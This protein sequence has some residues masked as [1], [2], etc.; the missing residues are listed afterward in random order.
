ML[1]RANDILF[2]E[3]DPGDR[4]YIVRSG[5]VRILKREGGQMNTLAEFGP[6]GF[7]GEMSLLD[8]S[9]RSATVQACE[10][11]ELAVVDQPSLTKT[12]QSQP[13]WLSALLRV[14]TVR[15]RET[16][17]RKSH[18]DLVR[19]FPALLWCIL[20]EENTSPTGIALTNLAARMRSI[21]GLQPES[22]QKLVRAFCQLSLGNLRREDQ[23]EL[24]EIR[25][26]RLLGRLLSARFAR[27][28]GKPDP[29]WILSAGE[30]RI[31]TCWVEAA[32]THGIQEGNVAKVSYTDFMAILKQ[33][34]PGV[35]LGVAALSRME[36]HGI[37]RIEPPQNNL[38]ANFDEILEILECQQMLTRIATEL[39][40][41]IEN[42]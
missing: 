33:R 40:A 2:V 6:G 30:Q 28:H 1:L 14:L 4:M 39:P 17:A 22:C 26:N 32:R 31:L 18:E 42:F 34:T 25:S 10:D 38:R 15:L 8:N 27:E 7:F 35:V 3:G 19:S 5:K 12:L 29:G 16:T 13:S 36:K 41:L 37:L 24:L 21:C 23:R 11:T 9:P 20:A